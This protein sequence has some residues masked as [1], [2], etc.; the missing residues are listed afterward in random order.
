MCAGDSSFVPANLQHMRPEFLSDESHQLPD[1]HAEGTDTY[2]T[3]GMATCEICNRKF[4]STMIIEHEEKCR[5]KKD[6]L[7]QKARAAKRRRH[8]G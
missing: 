5:R 2:D 8:E 7:E 6:R 3:D 1:S 4:A